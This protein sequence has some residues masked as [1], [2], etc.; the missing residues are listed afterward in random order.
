VV[1]DTSPEIPEPHAHAYYR[2]AD[3]GQQQTIDITRY[4]PSWVSTGGDMI[5]TTQDLHTFIAALNSGKL[6]PAELLS[7]MRTP[8]PTGIPNM[9]Y[10]LGVFVVTTDCGGTVISHNGGTVGSVA[11]MYSTPDGGTTLTA[12]LNYVDDADLSKAT[13]FQD[14]QRRL[15]NEVFCGGPADP[16]RPAD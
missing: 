1:P 8:H 9:D 11:L 6:L 16:V 4:N 13:A 10:G 2:Y 3:A 15:V 7:E 5:S 14:A 12:A